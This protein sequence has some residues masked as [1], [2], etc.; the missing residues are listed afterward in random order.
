MNFKLARVNEHIVQWSDFGYENLPLPYI[1]SPAL[2]ESCPEAVLVNVKW[3]IVNVGE[4]HYDKD[5]KLSGVK[6]VGGSSISAGDNRRWKIFWGC[7]RITA[8]TIA[9]KHDHFVIRYFFP[10]TFSKLPGQGC[11][12]CWLG[13]G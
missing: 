2:S 1:V 7:W 5:K 4:N 11:F 9:V 12:A 6:G 8:W 3:Q 13:E 10:S